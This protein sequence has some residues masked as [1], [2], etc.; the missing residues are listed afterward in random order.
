MR[1]GYFFLII[2]ILLV[3]GY[4][5]WIG[6]TQFRARRA[7]LP[8]PP[9]KSYIPFT[10]SS[11]SYRD[12]SYPSPR[13]GG[14][15]GWFKDRIATLRNR[16]SAFGGYEEPLESGMH[17]RRTDH[18]EAWDMRMGIESDGPYGAGGYYEEELGQAPG[19]EPYEGSEYGARKLQRD[20]PAHGEVERGRSRS[21]DPDPQVSSSLG[22]ESSKPPH[23]PFGDD[24]ERSNLRDVS[25]RPVVDTEGSSI[26]TTKRTHE[27]GRTE[28][29][30][31]FRE[32]L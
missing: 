13:H 15:T 20:T 26:S 11:S 10:S 6:F 22:D 9:W 5:A 17:G 16:R 12:S 8:P 18:D 23:D 24:T 7:G 2:I 32:S 21:R 4:A 28:R 1:W 19:R 29:E 27:R 30:S 14:I 31:M 25:H 3:V